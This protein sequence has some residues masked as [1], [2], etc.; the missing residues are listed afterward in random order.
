V[1]SHYPDMQGARPAM[2]KAGEDRVFIFEKVMAAAGGPA[3]RQVVKVTVSGAGK[4]LKV[5]ASR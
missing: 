5:V 3:L 4:V 1:Y 2:R